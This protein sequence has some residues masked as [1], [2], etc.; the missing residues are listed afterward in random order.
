MGETPRQTALITG[1]TSGIGLE[2][3][4]VFARHRYDLV[5]VARTKVTLDSLAKRLEGEYSI[6]CT[7]IA[8]DLSKPDAADNIFRPLQQDRRS[9]DV[10]I[11]NAGFG[12]WGK[13]HETD[14]TTE[15]EEI[16]LNVISLVKLTKLILPEM[17]KRRSGKI[18]NVAST[19]GFA[20]GPFMAIY[21]ATKAFVVS[22]TEALWEEVRESGVTIS[23]L[24][25]GETATNFQQRA[26]I[27]KTNLTRKGF[28]LDAATV[29]NCG[30]KG[31]M[32]GKVVIIPGTRNKILIFFIRIM[33]R[34]I[35]R[36][37]VRWFNKQR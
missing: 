22:F 3:T 5:L 29:A 8:C 28:V 4:K 11:N 2:L 26:G 23:V 25:P 37:V 10:L 17:I 7:T 31:L 18:L 30:F 6:K 15:M 24:C 20:P 1:A 33:P 35:V 27:E 16:Q 12:S 9:V 21:Y 13:F 14:L 19:A 34:S 32:R 36:S